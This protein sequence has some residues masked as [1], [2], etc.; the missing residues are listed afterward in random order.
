M[1]SES[2]L[3]ESFCDHHSEH[4]RADSLRH[5]FSFPPSPLIVGSEQRVTYRWDSRDISRAKRFQNRSSR[6]ITT[7]INSLNCS[8][9]A[10]QE[11]TVTEFVWALQL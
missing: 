2:E 9:A 3:G 1:T 4:T 8:K 10:L 11:I 6:Q 5:S 7:F